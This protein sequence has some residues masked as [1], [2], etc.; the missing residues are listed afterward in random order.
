MFCILQYCLHTLGGCVYLRDDIISRENGD[1]LVIN[2][3]PISPGEGFVLVTSDK[4]TRL[5]CRNVGS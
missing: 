3:F 1:I 5:K 2:N 4:D